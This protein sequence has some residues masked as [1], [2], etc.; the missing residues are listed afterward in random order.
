M[1]SRNIPRKASTE[2]VPSSPDEI[3]HIEM[4][5]AKSTLVGSQE[6]IEP[7]RTISRVPG[8]TN[9]YEKNGLRTEGDGIDHASYNPASLRIFDIENLY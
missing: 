1:A 5:H 2:K 3:K 6:E 8:N 9:Y 4:V 7:I